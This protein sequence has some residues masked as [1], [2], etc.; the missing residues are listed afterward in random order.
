M[1]QPSAILFV[2]AAAMLALP[3]AARAQASA[4]SGVIPVSG[5]RAAEMWAASPVGIYDVTL[6]TKDHAVP[7]RITVSKTGNELVALFWPNG[8]A[9]GQRMDVTVAGTELVLTARTRKGP[10]EV[11][12][13]RRG[14]KLDGTW[15]VGNQ[16]GS[17]KGAV[18]L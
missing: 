12:I 3:A 1:R 4:A 18:A 13:Q 16:H 10:M 15:N 14:Q 17:L 8:D 6:N 7:A 11:A 2:A 9:E 5:E